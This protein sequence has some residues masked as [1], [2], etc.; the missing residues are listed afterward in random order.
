MRSAVAIMGQG[1]RAAGRGK[2]ERTRVREMSARGE[3]ID[4]AGHPGRRG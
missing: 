3:V 4:G 1:R 2:G